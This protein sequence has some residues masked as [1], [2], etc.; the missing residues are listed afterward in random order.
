MASA[1]ESRIFEVNAGVILRGIGAFS[2]FPKCAVAAL[3]LPR[4]SPSPL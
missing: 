3:K 2:S 1:E 4:Y